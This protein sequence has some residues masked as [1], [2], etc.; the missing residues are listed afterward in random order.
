MVRFIRQMEELVAGQIP[1][2]NEIVEEF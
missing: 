1:L 2:E